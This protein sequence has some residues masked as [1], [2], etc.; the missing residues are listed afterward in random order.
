MS[1]HQLHLGTTIH[2]NEDVHHVVYKKDS[3]YWTSETHNRLLSG[4]F[5]WSEMV[6]TS[7]TATIDVVAYHKHARN[8]DELLASKEDNLIKLSRVDTIEHIVKVQEN[9]YELSGQLLDRAA[10]HD[11]SKLTEPELSSFAIFGPKLRSTTYGD[12]GYEDNRRQMGD[13]LAHHYA[14]NSHHPEHYETG[15]NGMDLIDILE[16]LAD[17]KAACER[18][19]D[20]N[21]YNSLAINAKRFNMSDQLVDIFY[22]TIQRLYPEIQNP[23]A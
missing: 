13:A 22:N 18:H 14:H 17:W 5:K 1:K 3:E 6:P 11:Q 20:G 15:V 21:L 7:K 9:L 19:D 8:S 23:N 10:V 4:E 2:H 12:E 16:M